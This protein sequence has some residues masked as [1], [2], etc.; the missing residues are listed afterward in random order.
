MDQEAIRDEIDKILQSST[1][2]DK[3]QLRALLEILSRHMDSQRTL[4]PDR[5]ARELWPEQNGSKGSRELA[6]E[7]YR[8]RMAL[9]RYYKGEGCYDPVVIKLPNRR[10]SL[11]NGAGATR[12]IVAEAGPDSEPSIPLPLSQPSPV[13][14]VAGLTPRRK[15][16][17][18]ASIAAVTIAVACIAMTVLGVNNEPNAV[19]LDGNILVVV[20]SEGKELWRKSFSG[21]FW[22][23]YYKPGLATQA[24]FTDLDGNG[25]KSV[26][27]FYHPAANATAH[28]TVL[29]CYSYRGK[30]KWR[31]TP[32]RVLPQL[33]RD[34]PTFIS[35]GLVIL[36][37]AH[38][39]ASR[40]VVVSE[41][42]PY[43]PAQ[44]A[45][46]NS[47]GRTTSEY[48]HSGHLDFMT[49]ADLDGDGR[50]EIIATGVDNGYRQA[51]LVVL[52][53]DRMSGASSEPIRRDL[54][55]Q[56]MLIA[57]ERLRLLFPRSDL[58]LASETY[59]ASREVTFSNGALRLSVWECEMDP[60]CLVWYEFD[61][62]FTLRGVSADDRFRVVHQR[63]YR[64]ARDD[65][66]FT[67]EEEAQF[68]RIRCLSG[69][70]TEF[71]PVD[72]Q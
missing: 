70:Q 71:V 2:A 1:L 46:I 14:Q 27:L 15:V 37:A 11:G 69:C 16:K 50:E 36:K 61:S 26:L 41:D 58:N 68:R 55:I 12:W 23:E 48:W 49:K 44:I 34:P 28:S 39:T 31:W 65:H 40:I 29:I 64:G 47:Q 9:E 72:I 24:W 51:T 33:G 7:M 42:S 8:L 63:Y 21:G 5:V 45:L 59:N 35:R 6:A 52:D 38:G 17:A 20:N 62:H 60:Y 67:A 10:A 56:G 43:Y 53:P 18:I 19:R 32:G 30:E 13:V 3:N 25:H 54:Q 66:P 4:K 57:Q 22:S